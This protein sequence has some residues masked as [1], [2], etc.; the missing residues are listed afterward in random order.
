MA[1]AAEGVAPPALAQMTKRHKKHHRHHHQN[2]KNQAMET[3]PQPDS[4]S[5]LTPWVQREHAWS[6]DQHDNSNENQFE[7][8]TEKNVAGW[9]AE[10]DKSLE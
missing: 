6:H 8:E 1:K 2:K 9:K 5:T 7:A 10:A 3:Y 4:H